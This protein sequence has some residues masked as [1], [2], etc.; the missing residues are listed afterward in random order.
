MNREEIS[1]QIIDNTIIAIV[2]TQQKINLVKLVESYAK[3]GITSIEITMNT[4]GALEAVQEIAHKLPEV[5]IGVGTVRNTGEAGRAIESGAHYLVTPITD[6]EI[7]EIAHKNDI[8]V[9]MGA[10]TPTEVYNA[11]QYGADLIKLFP[12]ANL[13]PAYMKAVLAPMPP[14]R[15][16]PTGGINLQNAQEWLD[17]GASAL[18]VGSSLVDPKLI[19]KEDFAGLTELARKFASLVQLSA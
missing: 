15:M 10:F 16:V 19:E 4:P 6:P 8:P 11:H 9:A 7:I 13:G 17:A 18:G 2:R 12:A 14:M 5:Q 3:G 1:Q